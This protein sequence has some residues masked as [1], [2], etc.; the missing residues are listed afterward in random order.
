MESSVSYSPGGSRT[1]PTAQTKTPLRA[2]KS[3]PLLNQS[4]TGRHKEIDLSNGGVGSIQ[5]ETDIAAMYCNSDNAM[6]TGDQRSSAYENV[7]MPSGTN[8]DDDDDDYQF[9]DGW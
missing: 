1:P 2:A 5:T 3:A 8:D 6:L 9:D 7:M 4:L